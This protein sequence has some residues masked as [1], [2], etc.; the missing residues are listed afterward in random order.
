MLSKLERL[1]DSEHEALAG[2]NVGAIAGHVFLVP[3]VALS[4]RP[5]IIIHLTDSTRS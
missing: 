5:Q 4:F 3:S 2:K 1:T